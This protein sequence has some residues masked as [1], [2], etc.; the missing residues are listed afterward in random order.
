MHK[1]RKSERKEVEEEM[2]LRDVAYNYIHDACIEHVAK[3][4][5]IKKLAVKAIHDAQ[6]WYVKKASD[7]LKTVHIKGLFN[8]RYS[9]FKLINTLK[10]YVTQEERL[11][12]KRTMLKNK[13]KTAIE[14]RMQG[15]QNRINKVE[16][17]IREVKEEQVLLK[18]LIDK[19]NDKNSLFVKE[20]RKEELENITKNIK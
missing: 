12:E 17:K 13:L 7:E 8:I 16:K 2:Y 19:A 18:Q 3:E 10:G 1:K 6:W 15:L 4:L 9:T 20:A 11:K 14:S 5:N